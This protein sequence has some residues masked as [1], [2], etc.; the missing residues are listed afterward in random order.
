M[1]G[2]VGWYRRDF[3]L[4]SGAFARYV[5]ARFRQLDHPLRIGQLPR[6]G[7]AQRPPDRQLT[8]ARICRSSSTLN[9]LRGGVNRLIV[10]VDDRRSP[11]DLPPGPGGGW[12]NFG[13][14]NQ[15]VYLRAVQRA[16]M[17]AR[18]G[19]ADPAVPHLRGD[20]RGAGDGPQLDRE[21]ADR[22]PAGLL[23]RPPS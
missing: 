14:I 3:T 5:P 8:P 15:E 22:R 11:A 6:H 1:A 17:L 20:D 18:A 4:P 13:G 19:A 9:A 23:R 21:P 7:V 10:R 12:W 16:D 2:S